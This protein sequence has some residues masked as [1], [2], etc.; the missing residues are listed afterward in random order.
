MDCTLDVRGLTSVRH[1]AQCTQPDLEG[2]C[3]VLH[4]LQK[5]LAFLNHLQA[6]LLISDGA[7]CM[8]LSDYRLSNR[9]KA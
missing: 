9:N 4:A 6:T 7:R 2:E 3:L 1:K 8:M 5:Q